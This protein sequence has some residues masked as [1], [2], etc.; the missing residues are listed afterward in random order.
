MMIVSERANQYDNEIHE[1]IQI[2]LIEDKQRMCRISHLL[3][4]ST[5]CQLD[6]YTIAINIETCS[7]VPP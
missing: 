7:M 4:S 6:R 5:V 3:H 1:I 2:N